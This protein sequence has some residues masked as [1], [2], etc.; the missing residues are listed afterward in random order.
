MSREEDTALMN[1]FWAGIRAARPVALGSYSQGGGCFLRLYSHWKAEETGRR[2]QKQWVKALAAS[3]RMSVKPVSSLSVKLSPGW[4]SPRR[5]GPPCFPTQRLCCSSCCQARTHVFTRRSLGPW[6]VSQTH[7]TARNK[8][9]DAERPLGNWRPS[10][11]N[12]KSFPLS[13]LIQTGSLDVNSF[14]H[15]RGSLSHTP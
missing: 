14:S 2:P 12:L 5:R 3:R 15:S 4:D 9:N 1:G 6:R 13:L 10:I 11:V 8:V 7:G